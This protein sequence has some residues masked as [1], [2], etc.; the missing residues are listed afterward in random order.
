M[1]GKINF[2]GDI[3]LFRKF[4][5]LNIDPFLQLQLPEADFNI[6]NLEFMVP[7]QKNGFFYDVQHHYSCSY[8][9]AQKLTLNR[10]SAF[11]LANNHSLD[12]GLQGAEE[13]IDLLNEKE[14]KHFGFSKDSGNTTTSI[15]FNG[16]KTALIGC[17][18]TGRWTKEKYGF[19]PDTY[20]IEMIIELISSLKVSHDHVVVF[21]HWGTELVEVPDAEDVVNA[22]KMIDAGALAVIG[23]HPHVCQGIEKYKNGLIAYSLGSFLYV[24]E[25]ELGFSKKN[26]NRL[27]SLCLNVE[28]NKDGIKAFEPVFYKYN[29]K[30]KIPEVVNDSFIKNYADHLNN[31]IYNRKLF[32]NQFNKA[33]IQREF[34][35]FF[36][37]LKENPY[38]TI[39]SYLKLINTRRLRKLTGI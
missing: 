13:T 25:E 34:R 10:F 37:R 19:G 36:I 3:G 12:Y 1:S 31:N 39:L 30:T 6:G 15:E 24:H 2:F 7:K 26:T 4:E 21:V 33:F 23:H 32:K 35:S 27:Y 9:Y 14:V 5:E 16:I 8:E 20:Q 38:R 17:V 11:G 18:K 28:I 29:I 22:K